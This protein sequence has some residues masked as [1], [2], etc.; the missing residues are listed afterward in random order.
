[1]QKFEDSM[2]HFHKAISFNS[3]NTYKECIK[4]GTRK[5]YNISNVFRKKCKL[6]ELFLIL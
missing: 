6:Y 3:I 4:I 1:M 5:N 2:K